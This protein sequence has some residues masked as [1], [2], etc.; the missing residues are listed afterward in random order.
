MTDRLCVGPEEWPVDGISGAILDVAWVPGSAAMF[1]VVVAAHVAIFDLSSPPPPRDD[2][3]PPAASGPTLETRAS[4]V[5]AAFARRE[6]TIALL[7]LSEDGLGYCHVFPESSV[8]RE[9]DVVVSPDSTM[10]FPRRRRR[11]RGVEPVV[12]PGAPRRV[13]L[14]DGGATVASAP[15]RRPT[16]SNCWAS[17]F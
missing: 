4:I 15:T 12:L 3:V 11:S 17:T 5:A 7:L 13:R 1:A 10:T 16:I 8:V 2:G 6:G 9:A 14:L